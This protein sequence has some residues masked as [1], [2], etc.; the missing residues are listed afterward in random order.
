LFAF[1]AL[2]ASYICPSY[3]QT[4]FYFDAQLIF[5]NALAQ[6]LQSGLQ[7]VSQQ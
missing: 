1:E 2:R 7:Q 5:L 6:L 4:L 3:I